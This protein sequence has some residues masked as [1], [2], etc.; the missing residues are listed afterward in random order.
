M[1]M[2]LIKEPQN[3]SI[4]VKYRHFYK[5]VKDFNNILLALRE[6]ISRQYCIRYWCKERQIDQLN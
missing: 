4:K 3:T 5:V 1:F 2:G 6:Q